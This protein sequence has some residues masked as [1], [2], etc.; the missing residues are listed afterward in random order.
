MKRIVTFFMALVLT[1]GSV[2]FP[3]ALTNSNIHIS[4]KASAATDAWGRTYLSYGDFKY[5]VK[6]DGTVSIIGFNINKTT[7]EI[8]SEIDGQTVTEIGKYAF[9]QASALT[10]VTIPDTVTT[11][12][13]QSFRYCSNLKSV[14]LPD[15]VTTLKKYAF[16]Q[17]GLESI[18]VPE[19]VNYIYDRAFFSCGSLKTVQ[20]PDYVDNLGSYC[21]YYCVSLESINLPSNITSIGD[22]QFY[23]CNS[24]KEISIP[25]GVTKIYDFAFWNCTSLTEVVLPEGVTSLGISAFECCTSLEKINIPSTVTEIGDWAFYEDANTVVTVCE[26]TAGA[27][28]MTGN[29]HIKAYNM[30]CYDGSGTLKHQFAKL[31]ENTYS[32]RY[33]LIVDEEDAANAQT[34]NA[35]VSGGEL[36]TGTISINAAYRSVYASGKLVSAGEGKVFLLCTLRNLSTDFS[37][38]DVVFRFDNNYFS[39]TSV[40]SDDLA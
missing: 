29:T 25:S 37:E 24:L 28:Y 33:L 36:S 15:S 6:T 17:T 30:T 22:H 23:N 9:Y 16:A 13:E 27:E 5:Q 39:K 21:F 11:I 1:L 12:G 31:N 4:L 35:C 10:E 7:A 8:P 40:Y 18:V 38:L 19:S 3:E 32:V 14:T 2:M 26:N 20:L 34:V